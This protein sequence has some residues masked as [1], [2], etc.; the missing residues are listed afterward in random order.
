MYIQL[1]TLVVTLYNILHQTEALTYL[2]YCVCIYTHFFT[3]LD[4]LGIITRIKKLTSIVLKRSQYKVVFISH[5][6]IFSVE[7]HYYFT[8]CEIKWTF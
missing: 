6:F 5:C 2:L 8:F 4:L 1:H 3:V 7:K